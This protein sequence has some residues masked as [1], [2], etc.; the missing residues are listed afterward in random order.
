MDALLLGA[1]LVCLAVA[2]VRWGHDS[3]DR[4]ESEEEA[5]AR[6]SVQ[7]PPFGSASLVR[8]QARSTPDEQPPGAAALASARAAARTTRDGTRRPTASGWPDATHED[9]AGE[10][11]A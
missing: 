1:L 7:W 9:Q 2:A 3:R 4:V 8:R 5:L 6:Q 11:P 10:R